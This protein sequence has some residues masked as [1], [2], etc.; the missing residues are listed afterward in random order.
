LVGTVAKE[1]QADLAVLRE[2]LETVVKGRRD[3]LWPAF[4]EAG[5]DVLGDV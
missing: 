1:N 5:R 3:G 2:Y 4:Y